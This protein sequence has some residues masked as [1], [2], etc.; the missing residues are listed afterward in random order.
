MTGAMDIVQSV[1]QL[2]VPDIGEGV[3]WYRQVLG[4]APD[5]QPVEGVAEWEILPGSWFQV[6]EAR[7]DPGRNR[8]RL[9]VNNL[10]HEIERL[11]ETPGLE[12]AEP[13]VLEGIIVYADGED[14]F[15]NRIG[16]FQVLD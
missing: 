13:V 16:L 14:P 7:P 4:R 8:V 1:M 5:M 9:G 11:R 12:L 6:I 10:E 2:R 15:G 3:E